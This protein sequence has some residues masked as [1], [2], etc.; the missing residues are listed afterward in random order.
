MTSV[1][2]FT[3]FAFLRMSTPV[4]SPS[5]MS[6]TTTWKEP[7]VGMDDL[8]RQ[9]KPKAGPHFLGGKEGNEDFLLDFRC[10]SRAI[11]ADGYP[12]ELLLFPRMTVDDRIRL[13]PQSPQVAEVAGASQR[14][15]HPS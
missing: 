15:L 10:Y 12:H 13:R 1:S 9:R 8:L 14:Y 7:A 3:S 2:E 11:V 6:V 5:R 4:K